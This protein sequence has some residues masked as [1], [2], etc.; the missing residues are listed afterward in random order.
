MVGA[1]SRH[2]PLQACT[3]KALLLC[4]TLWHTQRR[5]RSRALCPCRPRPAGVRS[6][7]AKKVLQ[8]MRL[9]DRALFYHSNAKPPGVVGIVE[10]R[11]LGVARAG[12]LGPAAAPARAA[13]RAQPA[14][15]A[16]PPSPLLRSAAH[17]GRSRATRALPTHT[18]HPAPWLRRG[19]RLCARRTQTTRSLTARASTTMRAA[20]ERRER[21][22][23]AGASPGPLPA[24]L[25]RRRGAA[26]G[27][28]P[29]LLPPALVSPASAPLAPD[30]P[31]PSAHALCAPRRREAPKWFMV[32]CRLERKLRR[33][34][35]LEVGGRGA[36]PLGCAAAARAFSGEALVAGAGRGRPHEAITGWHM[37]PVHSSSTRASYCSQ[38]L[39]PS[40]PPAPGAQV[41]LGGR[42]GKH[43]PVQV[44]PPLGAGAPP[45]SPTCRS[46]AVHGAR[47]A[48]GRHLC[49]F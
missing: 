22:M 29:E 38:P 18:L 31:S 34:I 7:Q 9:G 47:A 3:G 24:P 12:G 8:S 44:R 2:V 30:A 19:C 26:G 17:P 1:H 32:D 39:P 43:G 25:W 21:Q 10:V 48:V 49:R 35:P 28:P 6:H 15:R 11:R 13:G 33:Q 14:A 5:P 45:A 46:Q 36:A 41:A 27:G 23:G 37:V 42:A 16:A 40:C 4:R 20:R